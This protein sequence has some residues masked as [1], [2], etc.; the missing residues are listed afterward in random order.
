[1][2]EFRGSSEMCHRHCT[3]EMLE[4]IKALHRGF[5]FCKPDVCYQSFHYTE[6]VNP[7]LG[8]R[9]FWFQKPDMG[10]KCGFSSLFYSSREPSSRAS[11]DSAG[12]KCGIDRR[13]ICRVLCEACMSFCWTFCLRVVV[14]FFSECGC[15]YVTVWS[16]CGRHHC[17]DATVS[18]DETCVKLTH[19]VVFV[20]TE[21]SWFYGA[22]KQCLSIS[23]KV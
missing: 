18:C 16:A 19:A 9:L 21:G 3:E 23:P 20:W 22:D 17:R 10:P 15:R 2:L 8:S 6:V 5:A 12:L 11:I 13:G 4:I 1:M 14:G 7:S